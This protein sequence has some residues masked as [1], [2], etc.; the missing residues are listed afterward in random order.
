[1]FYHNDII[2]IVYVDDGLFFGNC[3]NNEDQDHSTDYVGDSINKTYA[4]INDVDIGNSYT[5]PVLAK[6]SFQLHAFCD[7]PKF[8]GNFNYCSAVGNLNYLRQTTRPDG[9]HAVHQVTNY[10]AYP[11]LEDVKAIVFIQYDTSDSALSKML[12]KAFNAT[13]IRILL[14]NGTESLQQ[15]ILALPNLGSQVAH[16]TTEAE[17]IAMSMALCDIIPLMELIKE[18]RDHKFNIVNMQP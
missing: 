14:D 5:K 1:M 17:Y 3:L 15:L 4:I 7:P 9:L 18:M 10:S 16:S 2:F 6:V 8:D 12:R 11:R 13:V